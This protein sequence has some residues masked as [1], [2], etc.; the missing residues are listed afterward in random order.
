MIVKGTSLTLMEAILEPVPRAVAERTNSSLSLVSIEK[1]TSGSTVSMV[2]ERVAVEE[3][4]RGDRI[5]GVLLQNN[6]SFG[7]TKNENDVKGISRLL[8]D[9]LYGVCFDCHSSDY[10]SAD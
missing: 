6:K 3:R 7:A 9:R 8:R 5:S 2:M 1:E 10:F 4:R